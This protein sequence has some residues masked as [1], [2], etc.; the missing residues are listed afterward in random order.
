M[1]KFTKVFRQY[2][3]V[4]KNNN[5]NN[6]NNKLRREIKTGT[7]GVTHICNSRTSKSEG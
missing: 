6:N 1:F 5:N 7:S 2:A 4:L 3:Y